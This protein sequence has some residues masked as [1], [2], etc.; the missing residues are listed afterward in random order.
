VRR[1]S[2]LLML[3]VPLLV[4][5]AGAGPLGAGALAALLLALGAPFLAPVLRLLCWPALV[6]WRER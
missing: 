3:L 1:R 6:R 5:L 2:A 4:A